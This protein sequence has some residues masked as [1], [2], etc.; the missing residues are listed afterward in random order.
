MPLQHLPSDHL[1]P[2]APLQALH[3]QRHDHGFLDQSSESEG[4][5]VFSVVHLHGKLVLDYHPPLVHHFVIHRICQLLFDLYVVLHSYH[6]FVVNLLGGH[7]ECL[8]EVSPR[9]VPL[10]DILDHEHLN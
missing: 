10:F 6:D 1:E 8:Q 4:D 7:Q 3:Q 9:S 5:H 2:Q